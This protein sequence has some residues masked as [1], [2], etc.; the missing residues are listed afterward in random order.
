[1]TTNISVVGT[2]ATEPRLVAS[3][4]GVQLCSFR[5]ASDERRFDRTQQ[6][7][8]EGNTNWFSVICFRSLAVHASE[9]FV[10]GDRVMVSGK[11]R[12][13]NWEN[14]E[15]HGTTVEIDA[16]AIGHDLR[17]GVSRFEKRQSSSTK[18]E[19]GH[20]RWLGDAAPLAEQ[21]SDGDGFSSSE[22]TS[23]HSVNGFGAD[24]FTPDVEAA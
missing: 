4:N 22:P 9:S 23:E 10:K 2:V 6:T 21:D 13:R 19:G 20:D 1:M 12:V 18:N 16:D 17:W 11:L 5:V 15:K 14:E 3:S 7:W 24:G 8:V